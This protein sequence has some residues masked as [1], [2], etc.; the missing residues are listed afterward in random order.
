MKKYTYGDKIK[1]GGR[2]RKVLTEKGGYIYYGSF[3]D[4]IKKEDYENNKN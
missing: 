1:I 3:A 4:K 2:E